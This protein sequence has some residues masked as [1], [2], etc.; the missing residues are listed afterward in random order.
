MQISGDLFYCLGLGLVFYYFFKLLNFVSHLLFW[1]GYDLKSRYYENDSWAIVTGASD[2]IGKEFALKFAS[3]GF[4]VVLIARNKEKTQKV[5][6]EISTTYK[7]STDCIICDFCQSGSEDFT[8]KLKND[9][10]KYP[11]IAILINNVGTGVNGFFKDSPLEEMRDVINVNCMSIVIMTKLC[12]NHFM[13]RKKRSL[14]I[15]LSS[16][17]KQYPIPFVSVY[18]ASKAFDDYLSRVIDIENGQKLDVLSFIPLFVSTLMT[19]YRQNFGSISTKEAVEGALKEVGYRNHTFGN[20]KHQILGNILDFVGFE[21]LFKWSVKQEWLM[22]KVK[23]EFSHVK[24]IAKAQGREYK[25][26]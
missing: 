18:G 6:E 25:T 3:L 5:A 21:C 9:L 4:N 8:K 7:V 2:G 11:D 14:I 22:N 19:G 10:Q 15:N 16:G 13:Q 23:K 17:T 24:L 20:W 12:I 26:D 1:K